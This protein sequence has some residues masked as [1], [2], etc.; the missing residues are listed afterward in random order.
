MLL[1]DDV[2]S[3]MLDSIRKVLP[4]TNSSDLALDKTGRC[5]YSFR[6]F[7]LSKLTGKNLDQISELVSP[8]IRGLPFVGKIKNES[9]YLNIFIKDSFFLDSVRRYLDERKQYP[10]TFQDP[11]RVLVE[12]TSTNPTGPIHIGRS[13]N[14]VIGDSLARILLRYGYRV[15]TQYYVN[16][17]GKQVAALYRGFE[18]FHPGETPTV[19]SLLSGYQKIYSEMQDRQKEKELIDPVIQS[20]EN[21]DKEVIEKIREYCSIMLAGIR[22]SMLS[23]GIKIDDYVWESSFLDGG[24]LNQVFESLSDRTEDDG[25]AKYITLPDGAKVYLRRS[26]GTSLYFARDIAYHIFKAMNA[27]W[28]ID[29]LGEDHKDHARHLSTVLK[30]YMDYKPRIDF[31]TYGFMSL[32]G[33]KFATRMGNIVTLD[34]LLARTIEEALKVVKEKRPDMPPEKLADVA[35]NVAISSIRFNIIR[36]NSVKHVDFRWKEALSFDGDAAPYILYAYARA[37]SILNRVGSFEKHMSVEYDAEERALAKSMFLY[38][39]FLKESVDSLRPEII[40]AYCL[41]LVKTFNDFYSAC[42]VIGS[43][44][45]IEK[46]VTL[47]TCFRKILRDAG[48]LIGIKFLEEM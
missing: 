5:D 45:E 36:V 23:I 2:Y 34:D 21:G 35:R 27:D 13:R 17:S 22:E 24:E 6:T 37:G 12:H 4:E 40:A 46:R 26:N 3:D 43:G 28:V 11:E 42:Q 33:S 39:Y 7:R 30:E 31:V 10:D 9:G 32:E 29:V 44:V 15:T 38:P 25:G 14:S 8:A 48:S 47:I 20:Y 1:F 16:D 41:D 19:D 18:M